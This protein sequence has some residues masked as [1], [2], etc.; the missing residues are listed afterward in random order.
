MNDRLVTATRAI[1]L[2]EDNPADMRLVVEALKEGKVQSELH[3]A[4][5]GKEAL[6]YLHRRGEHRN[7][8]RPALILLDL[9]LPRVDGRE[10]LSQIKADM[11]LR[12]IP[13]VVLTTSRAESDIVQSYELH[14]N[15]YINKYPDNSDSFLDVI[16]S[17]ARFWLGLVTLPPPPDE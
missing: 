11:L 16:L 5:D 6:D 9:N 13:V 10:V 8:A 1:L 3:W 17:I 4:Q 12:R 15:C 7:A 14:A 2:V